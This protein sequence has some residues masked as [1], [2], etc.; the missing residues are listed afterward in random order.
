M[1]SITLL[2]FPFVIC[3]Q[4]FKIRFII[5]LA[6]VS[7]NFLYN[8]VCHTNHQYYFPIYHCYYHLVICEQILNDQIHNLINYSC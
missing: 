6:F 4:I 7:Y 3:D 2:L 5:E 8:Y 1:T